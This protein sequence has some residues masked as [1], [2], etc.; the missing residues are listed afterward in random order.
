M[1]TQYPF[2]RSQF[3]TLLKLIEESNPGLTV[4]LTPTNMI[5]NGSPAAQTVPSGGIADTNVFIQSKTPAYFGGRRFE[6]RRID[7]SKAFKGMTLLLN[8]YQP[9]TISAAQICDELNRLYGLSL[10]TVDIGSANYSTGVQNT[11]TI[12]AGSLCYNGSITFTWTRTKRPLSDVMKQDPATINNRLWP[13]GNTF[14]VGRKPQGE[15]MVYGV[16]GAE[17]SSQFAS[18]SATGTFDPVAY[19]SHARIMMFMQR[20][21]PG[22]NFNDSMHDVSGGLKNLAF[23]KYTLPNNNVPEANSD[24]YSNVFVLSAAGTSWFQGR[25]LIHY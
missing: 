17:L 3:E 13:G 12:L 1:I 18:L 7:L 23:N 10:S 6:Y 15:Y 24:H 5:V 8:T 22:L 25:I 14:N 2:S 16:T 11:V 4:G 19:S 21:A 20:V 9:T